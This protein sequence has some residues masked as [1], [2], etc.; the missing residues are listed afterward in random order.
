[1][2]GVI[3]EALP[4]RGKVCLN[5]LG[6]KL[7]K[8]RHA[9]IL[10]KYRHL[11]LVPAH[12]LLASPEIPQLRQPFPRELGEG[13]PTTQSARRNLRRAHRYPLPRSPGGSRLR[14]LER[15]WTPLRTRSLRPR[16]PPLSSRGPRYVLGIRSV[17]SHSSPLLRRFLAGFLPPISRQ[18]SAPMRRP[19]NSDYEEARFRKNQFRA[20]W[21]RLRESNPG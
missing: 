15:P 11:A 8:G 13:V 16:C 7:V 9:G 5:V 3:R 21:R 2:N 6:L 17:Y 14:R 18:K 1:M 4:K 10:K 20:I 19:L 12:G